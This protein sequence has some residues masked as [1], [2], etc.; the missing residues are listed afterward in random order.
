MRNR[1]KRAAGG[2]RK[3]K[4]LLLMAVII[5]LAAGMMAFKGGISRTADESLGWNLMLV[6]SRYR[7]P[8][9]Y[10]VELI[11]LSNGEQVDSR[12]YPDLQEM[13]DDARG[14]G[15]SL[16][17]RAG[18]RSEE[19]QEN[20]MEDKI[21]AYRQEGYS[22]REAEREAEKWVAKPGTS[23]HELGLAVDIN[24]EGQTDGNRLY[25]WLADH[26]WKYGFILRY[27]AEKE[28]ITGIDYE[29]WHFRYVGK[30]A[31]KEMYEQDLCLEE[32]V[33]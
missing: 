19:D 27:P 28:E 18:Y 4:R 9:D 16:F 2:K 7:I 33:Q 12:I 25:Q 32:Y 8:D 3:G 20:L 26:S 22:Q 31:A 23:E 13:F 1:R 6:N 17:V 15:Y 5:L 21:E 14:A 11:R 30:Q 29:P 10:S 24:A